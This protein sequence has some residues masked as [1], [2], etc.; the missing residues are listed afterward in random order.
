[1]I[2]ANV[3]AAYMTAIA[4]RLKFPLADG[5]NALYY[6]TLSRSLTTEQFRDAA[7]RVFAEYDEF[8]FPPP[9]V[10]LRLAEG[11]PVFDVDALVRQIGKLGTYLPTMGDTPPVVAVVRDALGDVV[12]DAYASVGSRA[13]FSDDETTQ[14][15]ARRDFEKRLR[16]FAAMPPQDRR[17]LIAS[18]PEARALAPRNAPV[19]GIASIVTRALPKGTAA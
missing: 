3:F 19:E 5:T 7:E 11:T 17:R 15:I 1:M 16:E 14:S 10:F 18:P 2:D 6:T 12:A 9:S 8:G 4:D 13:L